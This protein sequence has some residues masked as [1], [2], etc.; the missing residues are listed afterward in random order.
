ML[1]INQK[2]SCECHGFINILL[3]VP[4]FEI[5]TD[6]LLVFLYLVRLKAH[7]TFL[8]LMKMSAAISKEDTY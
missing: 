6:I 4:F 8:M 1:T 3:R 7:Q 5:S 2:V